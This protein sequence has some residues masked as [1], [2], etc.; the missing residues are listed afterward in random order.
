MDYTYMEADLPYQFDWDQFSAHSDQTSIACVEL[1]FVMFSG[2][3]VTSG[4]LIAP[5]T[6][7]LL[8]IGL[9]YGPHDVVDFLRQA[10]ELEHVD[11][12]LHHPH[13][14]TETLYDGDAAGTSSTILPN[15]LSL[16]LRSSTPHPGSFRLV[17]P[18]CQELYMHENTNLWK[19]S[20]TNFQSYWNNLLFPQL[21]RFSLQRPDDGHVEDSIV[22][23]PIGGFLDRHP[24]LEVLIVYAP[25]GWNSEDNNWRWALSYL[26]GPSQMRLKRAVASSRDLDS[27]SLPSHSSSAVRYPLPGLRTLWFEINAKR[28][29][30][31]C[32]SELTALVKNI[33]LSRPHITVNF[34][35]VPVSSRNR[36]SVRGMRRQD[37]FPAELKELA[38]EFNPLGAG[39]ATGASGRLNLL[40]SSNLFAWPEAWGCTNPYES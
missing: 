1:M 35:A 15:L 22:W 38:A 32:W 27:C 19:E 20:H 13:G 25:Y 39:L 17:S 18:R 36:G 7:R 40:S 30:S 9:G 14:S 33:L 4:N 11:W 26:A 23:A 34:W 8:R 24:D 3:I 37:I 2:D 16:R 29:D 28:W 5:Q 6:A 21:K 31:E 10:P 12:D